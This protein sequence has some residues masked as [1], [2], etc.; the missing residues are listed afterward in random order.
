LKDLMN[1]GLLGELKG[2]LHL[3]IRGIHLKTS[4]RAWRIRE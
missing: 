4:W 3:N 2:N 1:G